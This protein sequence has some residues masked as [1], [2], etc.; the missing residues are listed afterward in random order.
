M[1]SS[2]KTQPGGGAGGGHHAL[3]GAVVAAQQHQPAT[4]PGA[5]AHPG[6]V[7]EQ[8]LAVD[9]GVGLVESG[10]QAAG[11]GDRVAV[12]HRFAEGL[13]G[14]GPALGALLDPDRGAGAVE[15][16]RSF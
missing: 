14:A 3:A 16:S 6:G 7:Q 2:E 15:S 13:A 9:Q 4:G 10:D 12:S 8:P 5:D 11:G 1:M